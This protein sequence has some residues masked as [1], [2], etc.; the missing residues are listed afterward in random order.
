MTTSP[1]IEIESWLIAFEPVAVRMQES[2]RAMIEFVLDGP[3]RPI[4]L[5]DRFNVGRTMAGRICRAIEAERVSDVALLLPARP[6]MMRLIDEA[7]RQCTESPELVEELRDAYQNFLR[8]ITRIASTHQELTSVLSVHDPR[9]LRETA[10]RRRATIF[11]AMTDEVGGYTEV[12]SL[13]AIDYPNKEDPSWGDSLILTG[14]HGL[15]RIGVM[16]P[17]AVG[18]ISSDP[19]KKSEPESKHRIDGKPIDPVSSTVIREL[20]SSELPALK[21]ITTPDFV[22]SIFSGEDLPHGS[23]VDLVV[24]SVQDRW[25]KNIRPGETG[26]AQESGYTNTPT[27]LLIIDLLVH[28]DM[29]P[30]IE[31]KFCAYNSL[32]IPENSYPGDFWFREVDY[33]TDL[34]RI[35]S[36]R[37]LEP[38]LGAPKHSK[39]IEYAIKNSGM[40]L[41]EFRIYRVG[42]RYPTPGHS[43]WMYFSRRPSSSLQ[44][45]SE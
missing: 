38:I 19:T 2:L 14:L 37:L 33:Y 12:S 8:Q 23:P 28:K 29:W 25:L 30:G 20:S 22:Y 31:P 36:A 7:E 6:T 21:A 13:V 39:M 44:P 16:Q 15:R 3:G 35:D 45:G 5:C 18:A 40:D 34:A 32:D 4:D 27:K 42:I 9:L 43:Y 10:E 26:T 41:S 24:G 17:I 1:S 11:R